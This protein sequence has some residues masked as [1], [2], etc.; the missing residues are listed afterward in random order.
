[1]RSGWGLGQSAVNTSRGWQCVGRAENH[2]EG[3]SEPVRSRRGTSFSLHPWPLLG[4]HTHTHSCVGSTSRTHPLPTAPPLSKA[5]LTRI[6]TDFSPTL[7]LRMGPVPHSLG[8]LPEAPEGHTGPP[9]PHSL[10]PAPWESSVSERCPAITLSSRRE[11]ALSQ[12]RLSPGLGMEKSLKTSWLNK[13]KTL[14]SRVGA[15]GPRLHQTQSLSSQI[16]PCPRGAWGLQ[17]QPALCSHLLHSFLTGLERDR[18]HDSSLTHT[19]THTHS[20]SLFLSLSLS[21]SSYR[22]GGEAEWNEAH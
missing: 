20:L 11:S 6:R 21:I 2:G 10:V 8:W 22:A 13:P 4:T 17:E 9:S 16:S 15:R 5:L 19:H 14:L 12:S 18:S 1:M 3:Q 7:K